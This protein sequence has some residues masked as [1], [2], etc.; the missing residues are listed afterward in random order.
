MTAE[1]E[2]TQL[3]KHYQ[4][5]YIYDNLTLFKTIFIHSFYLRGCTESNVRIIFLTCFNKL[6]LLK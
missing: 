1:T 4:Y 6:N 5:I 3:L 2:E